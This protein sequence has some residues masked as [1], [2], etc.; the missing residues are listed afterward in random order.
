MCGLGKMPESYMV[1]VRGT[2]GHKA[3]CYNTIVD[4]FEGKNNL[5]KVQSIVGGFTTLNEVYFK[6]GDELRKVILMLNASSG[7]KGVNYDS[8]SN[9]KKLLAHLRILKYRIKGFLLGYRHTPQ[10]ISVKRTGFG[11][12]ILT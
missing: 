11:Y 5:K 6:K 3:F 12:D 2:R 10:G 9:G 7:L 1:V 8:W 4:A